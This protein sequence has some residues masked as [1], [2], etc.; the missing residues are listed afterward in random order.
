MTLSS[1]NWQKS[2]FSPDGSNCLE[3]VAA[4]RGAIKLRESDDPGV[5]LTATTQEI[6]GLILGLKA[7]RFSTHF[8]DA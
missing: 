4:E 6:R 1:F 5:I 2:S 7:D 3:I 8:A